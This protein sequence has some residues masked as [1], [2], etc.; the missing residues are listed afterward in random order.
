MEEDKGRIAFSGEKV[1]PQGADVGRYPARFF[2]AFLKKAKEVLMS[3]SSNPHL[4]AYSR[5]LRKEMNLDVFNLFHKFLK[6]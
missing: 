3:Y 5:K 2:I 6:K 1:P 4:T